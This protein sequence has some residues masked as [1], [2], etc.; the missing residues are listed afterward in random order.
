MYKGMKRLIAL[1]S[2]TILSAA[3]APQ[4]GNNFGCPQSATPSVD[5]SKPGV[6][7]IGDS[8]SIGY[9]PFVRQ[10]LTSYDV[11]HNACNAMSSKNGV[12][13]IDSWLE[14]RTSW[15]VITFNHGMWDASTF[16][17]VSEAD[18]EANLHIIAQKIKAKTNRPIF[19]LTTEV[20]VNAPNHLDAR[21]IALNAIA[22][23][24]M[25]AEGIPVVDLYSVSKTL[26]S[27][28]INPA[29]QNDVHYSSTGSQ[30]LATEVLSGLNT[31]YGVH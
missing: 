31:N 27:E 14:L 4:G 9:T 10:A 20:P 12:S 24:V 28:H 21:V 18:Y 15:D 6:L 3:C 30:S 1:L 13:K 5:L 22:V 23:Q 17:H 2:L 26:I 7:V 11:V 16:A 29:L 8:I 19:M 25:T